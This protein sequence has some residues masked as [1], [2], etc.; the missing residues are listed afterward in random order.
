MA[1]GGDVVIR[2]EVRT[3]QRH[4]M[5]PPPQGA[6]R[7]EAREAEARSRFGVEPR[8]AGSFVRVFATNAIGVAVIGDFNSWDEAA[9]APLASAGD[10]FWE[11][12]VPGMVAGSEY[13]LLI[14]RGDGEV[15]HRLDVAARDTR[16]SSLDNWHNKSKVVDPTFDWTPFNTP[17]FDDLIL[18]QCHVGSFS[19]HRD[20]LIAPGDV[21]SFDLLQTKLDYIT[22]LGF[23]GLAL[24]PV[25]EFRADRSWGYNP[26]FF[27]ALESAYGSPAELRKLVDACHQRG[28]AVIFDVV[29]NHIS[30]D[31]SSFYHFD[32]QADG[33]GDSYLGDY[34]S[35]PWG[36]APAFWRQ[37]IKDFFLANMHMYLEEYRGDGLRFDSTRTME[38][39]RGW[40][41]DGWKFMQHLTWEGKRRF[42]GKYFIAEHIG[43]HDSIIHSAG[44]HATWV[45]EPFDRLQGALNGNDPVGNLEA[46]V[47]TS[48]GPGRVYAY[49]WNVIKY[50]LGSHDECGD[51][52]NGDEG[53][54]HFVQRF[55]GRDN[56]YAR[57]KARLAWALNAATSG[58][59]MMFMGG[60]CHQP[61]Y[62]H[63]GRDQHGDHRFD[64]S[65]A[66]DWMG[67]GMRLLV[68]A[69]NKTRWSNPALR[70]G[71]LE[72]THRDP[73][74][75]LAFKRWNNA[76]NVV[77]VVVNASDVS[78]TGTTYG[79]ATGQAGRWTQIL[80]SQDAWFGGWDGAGN[81][82]H[83]P[84]T[85]ADGRIYVNVPK[86]SV[87]MFRLL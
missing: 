9:P 76:G 75:V 6:R 55:G 51:L 14:T 63:D 23:N 26:S 74:G 48:F 73:S 17:V 58:T 60:E 30:N 49:S 19:G 67:M 22:K 41:D 82:Y 8:G 65:I 35:T 16:H 29:F 10:G 37:G 64:W 24:L 20:G 1:N 44:F 36:P 32:E 87:T 3:P 13:Q 77:L 12:T 47:G 5:E 57:A 40:G 86:W 39:T 56:W 31:D 68:E 78:Y 46:L 79:V 62:W 38:N 27:F 84:W 34:P 28:L 42:P 80:C 83:E 52:K 7:V 4:R 59:P 25:Q 53:K 61:G 72:V 54:R 43:D 18:Y 71:G 15:K 81:A 66:G 45:K 21:A 70:S 2:D 85:Q 69:A 50:L 33:N 11:A